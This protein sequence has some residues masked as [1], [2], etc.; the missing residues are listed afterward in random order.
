MRYN[1]NICSGE[2]NSE[3]IVINKV[4]LYKHFTMQEIDSFKTSS[5]VVFPDDEEIKTRI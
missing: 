5:T 1:I 4:D 2:K 3:L